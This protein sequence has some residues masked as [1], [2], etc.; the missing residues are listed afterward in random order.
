MIIDLVGVKGK[1]KVAI[2]C[3]TLSMFNKLNIILEQGKFD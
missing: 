2:E 1:D 3:G